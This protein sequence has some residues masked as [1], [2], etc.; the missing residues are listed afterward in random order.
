MSAKEGIPKSKIDFNK[1]SNQP[2]S[3]KPGKTKTKEASQPGASTKE[4]KKP[5]T[6][7]IDFDKVDEQLTSKSKT[8]TK[9]KK[10]KAPKST[11][12][13]KK[14]EVKRS[15][16][17][18]ETKRVVTCFAVVVDTSRSMSGNKL[19]LVKNALLNIWEQFA[20]SDWVM[21][22]EFNSKP[23]LILKWQS[24]SKITNWESLVDSLNVN[25]GT[26]LY[27]AIGSTLQNIEKL[28]DLKT[29]SALPTAS[30]LEM[31]VLTD[32]EDTS[33]TAFTVNNLVSRIPQ[34]PN[35]TFTLIGVELT[36]ES[37]KKICAC[38]NAKYR[39]IQADEI[40]TTIEKTV[41]EAVERATL[42]EN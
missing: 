4:A 35:F 22:V 21:L 23:N 13:D 5:G 7:K 8:H 37:A 6:S 28:E 20:S 14:S 9:E 17:P 1:I 33:S 38:K 36:T 16:V 19:Q 27:D 25:A 40:Q 29:G 3:S 2:K 15:T 11:P 34:I 32:G 30:R 31:I 39:P 12:S 24:K 41:T 18:T 10:S 42:P 26:A